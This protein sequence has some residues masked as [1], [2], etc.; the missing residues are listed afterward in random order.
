MKMNKLS[1]LLLAGLLVA[2]CNNRKEIPNE[3]EAASNTYLLILIDKTLSTKPDTKKVEEFRKTV[4]KAIVDALQKKG[5]QVQAHF[6]HGQTAGAPFFLR[7]S[8]DKDFVPPKGVGGQDIAEAEED[9]MQEL[10]SLRGRCNKGF[11]EAL[12][13][14]NLHDTR[15]QTDLW[16][17]FELMSRFFEGAPAGARKQVFLLSDMMESSKGAGR[18][19]FHETPIA[20]QSEA[21][22]LAKADVK[23][24]PK[25]YKINPSALQGIEIDIW[26]PYK[27]LEASEMQATRYYWEA[28]FEAYGLGKVGVR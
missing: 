12:A 20:D 15:L 19:D 5:D 25:I 10:R 11:R 24:I 17:S 13:Q 27:A 2:S 6:I 18:R 3:A 4:S 7:E 26:T 14:E 23:A 9:Y 21:L 8:V 28:L 22:A 16:G 1:L